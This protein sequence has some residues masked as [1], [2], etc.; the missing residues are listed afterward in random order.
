MN[1][2]AYSTKHDCKVITMKDLR[3]ELV[4]IKSTEEDLQSLVAMSDKSE[5]A[6]SVRLLAINIAL[7]KKCFGDLP[8]KTYENFFN[9]DVDSDS[10]KVFANGLQ[11]AIE[12]LNMVLQ[13]RT[14]EDYEEEGITIN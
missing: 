12:M 8:T 1:F 4:D 2:A 3:L 5:L 14:L 7:Y 11:E 13:S 6:Q 9:V 10:A